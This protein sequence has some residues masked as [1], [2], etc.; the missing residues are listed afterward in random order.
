[1]FELI[2]LV[3]NHP[4]KCVKA[5]HQ[6]K[7]RHLNYKLMG[8]GIS[9]NLINYF[10]AIA[11]FHQGTYEQIYSFSTLTG[12]GKLD[13]IKKY[14]HVNSLVTFLLL[15]HLKATTMLK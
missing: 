10:V 7:Y 12:K 8:V 15:F 4:Q 13:V 11:S 5:T 6:T 9:M 2:K 3:N 1:M 14:C